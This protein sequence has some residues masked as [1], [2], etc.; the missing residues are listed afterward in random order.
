[1]DHV[2]LIFKI[3]LCISA[4]VTAYFGVFKKTIDDRGR[5]TSRGKV[6]VACVCITFCIGVGNELIGLNEKAKSSAEK[7]AADDRVLVMQVKLDRASEDGKKRWDE[8][9]AYMIEA[10]SARRKLSTLQDK[11]LKLQEK[12]AAIDV[13]VSDPT[14]SRM[15]ADMRRLAGNDMTVTG[16][17]L[18]HMTSILGNIHDDLKDAKTIVGEN[19]EISRKMQDELAYMRFEIDLIKTDVG[20]VKSFVTPVPSN[21]NKDAGVESGSGPD[22]ESANGQ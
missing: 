7:R 11:F 21:D 16:E 15:I 8:T 10:D 4:F 19:R 2:A 20:R 14:L 6:C 1:M 9:K 3:T 17:R 13:R 5:L 22:A 18:G 12:L